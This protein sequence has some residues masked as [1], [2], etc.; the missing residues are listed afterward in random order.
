MLADKWGDPCQE[1][2]KRWSSFAISEINASDVNGVEE[3]GEVAKHSR[4]RPMYSGGKRVIILDEFQKVSNSAQNLLLKPFEEPAASTV[5]IVCT[6][7][8]NKIL[9]TLRRR[10][11]TFTL[12]G[13]NFG[14]AEKFL[15]AKAI[16]AKVT[17]PLEPLLEQANLLGIN[18]PA[19]L[20]QALEKYAAG[21][22]AQEA[23]AGVD[24][25]G[26]ESLRIC[27]SVTGGKWSE[28][29][30]SMKDATPDSARLIRASV[31]GW[32]VGCLKR[33]NNP[34]GQE[35]AAL[36]LVELSQ[37]PYDDAAMLHWLW[38]ALWKVT[39]RYGQ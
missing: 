15:K 22:S 38:G 24:E 34:K 14:D 11:T 21:G 7:E 1:C 32:L 16:V 20:L 2:W 39:R 10:C 26:V 36:S 5:W 23:V 13:L 31:S 12:K 8:P 25:S 30:N 6:T 4:Y 27:K 9:Q 37:F 28:V 29:V 35:R 33:E 18:A 19:M 3:L 17:R